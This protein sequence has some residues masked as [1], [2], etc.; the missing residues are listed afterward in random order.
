MQNS[1]PISQLASAQSG[2]IAPAGTLNY[3]NGLILTQNPAV[4]IGSVMS[5]SAANSAAA[6]GAFFGLSSPEYAAAQLY[7]QGPD[8]STQTPQSILFAQYPESAVSGYLRGGALSLTL[9]QLQELT[10]TLTITFAGT[11]LTSSSINLSSAT[12]FSNA[13]TVIAAAFTS[14]P[15]AV[16]YD[17]QRNAF[18]FTST[19]TGATETITYASGSLAAGLNLTQATGAVLSQGA[20]AA[21]IN[22]FMSALVGV[23]QQWFSFTTMWEPD[24][25]DKTSFSQWTSEQSNGY[26]YVGYDSD[27]NVLN[28]QG[29]TETWGYA[30]QQGSYSGSNLLAGTI[31]QAMQVMGYYASL[32]FEAVNGRTTLSGRTWVGQSPYVS[33]LTSYTNMLANGYSSYCGFASKKGNFNSFESGSISGPYLWADSYANQAWLRDNLQLALVK[34]KQQS[35]AIPYNTDGNALIEAAVSTVMSQFTTFG[36]C[37]NGVTL[38]QSQIQEITSL[39]GGTDISGTLFSQGWYLF[40][41]TATSSTRVSRTSGPLA[42]FYVDG[43]SVQ[44]IDLTAYEV[45]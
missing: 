25:S 3:L 45:Q 33:D 26:A 19:A 12:S 11:A 42:L 36:G 8:N 28:Q 37:V 1:I 5:F 21:T 17:S 29:S 2:V 41:G 38:S 27:P 4:P 15:F 35:N 10:G 9:T 14:P 44:V 16:A 13:A 20:A 24:V 32:N 30:V 23:N 31:N 7:A 39:T 22:A 40:I 34:A 18:T 43:Q 6:V